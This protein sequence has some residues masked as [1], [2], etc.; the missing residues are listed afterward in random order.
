MA[1]KIYTIEKLVR[2]RLDEISPRF[3]S[4]DELTQIIIAGIKDL[5]RDGSNLKQ[6]YFI[7]V[8]ETVTL[9]ASTSTLS[10]LPTDVHKVY[11]IEPLDGSNDSDNYG[12]VFRPLDYNDDKFVAARTNDAVDPSNATIWYAVHGAGAPVGAPTIRVA[13]Q[14]TSAVSIRFTYIPTVSSSL[15]SSS[16]VPIPGDADNALVA[17][18]VAYARAKER[19]DRAPDPG[20]L[21]LYAG[22]KTRL[23]NSL[24]LRQLQEREVVEAVFEDCW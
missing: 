18:T 5:W 12:L 19:D 14:V 17:W 23:M 20:W 1:T 7:T 24:G 9:A 2:Q 16:D 10:G 13:P 11:M 8:D 4:S 6:E 21:E 22:E 15:A 3:W